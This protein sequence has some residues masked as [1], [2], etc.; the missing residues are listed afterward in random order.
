MVE[1]MLAARGICVTYETV[2]V[3]EEVRQGIRRS[4]AC[5]RLLAATNG[6]WMV[7]HEHISRKE[8][9]GCCLRE[10][11]GGPLEASGQALGLKPLQAAIVKS[12]GGERCSKR[13]DKIPSECESRRGGA[14]KRTADEVS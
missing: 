4:P 13:W 12:D 6:I 9:V 10:M 11:S 2:P 8:E 5:Q 3:G 7:C 1:E 14:R